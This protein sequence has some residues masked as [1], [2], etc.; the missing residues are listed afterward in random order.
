MKSKLLLPFILICNTCLAQNGFTVHLMP[1]GYTTIQLRFKNAIAIDNTNNKWI[2]F[3]SIGLGKYDGVNWTMFDISNSQL[4]VND[5][6]SIAF[7]ASSNAWIGT[8][9]GGLAKFDGSTWTIFN[10]G[11][12]TIASNIIYSVTVNG[13]DIW[14][15]TNAG[16]SKY[17]GTTFTNYTVANSNLSSDTVQSFAFET[18]GDVWMGSANGLCK[19]SG[20]TWTI[21]NTSN[22]GLL[23]D[24]VLSL[25]RDGQNLWIGTKLGGLHKHYNGSIANISVM[26][27]TSALIYPT[28]VYSISKGPQGGVA[29]RGA[30]NQIIEILSYKVEVYY[31]NTVTSIGN[32]L[33]YEN[34]SGLLWFVNK[35]GANTPYQDLMSFTNSTYTGF[36]QGGPFGGLTYDNTKNLDINEVNATILNRGDM[37]WNL[38]SGGYEVPKGSGVGTVFASAIWI[39]GLDAG[40]NLHT[41]A[42]TYRQTG[43]DYWP[44]PLDTI[45]FS[46]DTVTANKY[47]KIWKIDRFKIAEFIYYFNN[48]SVQ[49]GTYAVDPDILSWPAHGTGN[50]SRNLAPFVDVDG[51]GIYNPMTGGDYPKIKGDQMLYWIFNDSILHTE[52]GGAP[53]GFEIHASAYAFTCPTIADSLKTLNYTT[54]YNYKIIN[55]S[56]MNYDSLHVGLWQDCDMGQYDDDYVGCMPQYNFGMGYNG[57]ADDN[58]GYGLKPPISSQV[59]LDGPPAYPSDGIDND[60]DGTTDEPGEK[61]LM[62]SFNY[63]NNDFT[64]QMGNPVNDSM[65]YNY[66]KGKRGDGSPWID[67]NN[68]PSTFFYA[69]DPSDIN[70]C[71]EPNNLNAPADRRFVTGCGAFKLIAGDTAN[72]DYAIVFSR[73]TNLAYGTQQYYQMAVD[74]V[75]RVR[76]WYLQNNFPSCLQLNVGM[77]EQQGEINS[78]AIY[79]NPANTVL[80]I[81]Y[82]QQNP[83]VKYEVVD[84]TGKLVAVGLLVNFGKNIISVDEF[85]PGLYLI[86]ITDGDKV[87]SKK[88]LK[89]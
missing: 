37:H 23:D 53:F 45:N 42:M 48:G 5:V 35:L 9:G 18:N 40:G 75:R 25:F 80:T 59:I 72:I 54:Y 84:V 6:R 65:F 85:N 86:K 16:V 68:I 63:Y 38:N 57:D 56:T 60:N 83:N 73:D 34:S 58:G 88:F 70:S 71:A 8:N 69:G 55:Q 62:T 82:L 61:N 39:G 7:D 78:M 52:T 29:C 44:G 4:P 10:T 26:M 31:A 67:C 41:S 46:T 1:T 28:A 24:N 22:S 12:S 19:L 33:A 2:G 64:P 15:G 17:N 87:I 50:N 32:F 43:M 81:E 11:N 14:I 89:Q 49:N 66:C 77:N 76:T 36:G 20:T 21:F 30:L 13:S 27:P 51:S 47:D 3:Q 79:P 74:D